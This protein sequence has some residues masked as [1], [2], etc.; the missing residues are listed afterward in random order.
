M[1]ELRMKF[2]FFD[3]GCMQMGISE[4]SVVGIW[5]DDDDVHIIR[6]GITTCTSFGT[7]C[8]ITWGKKGQGIYVC[9]YIHVQYIHM[10]CSPVGPSRIVLNQDTHEP[11]TQNV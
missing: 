5:N 6:Q 11:V 4:K 7:N 9:R 3:G 1:E 2:A 10:S 8:I